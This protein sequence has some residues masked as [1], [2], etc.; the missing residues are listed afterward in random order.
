MNRN[1][2]TVSAIYASFGR[3]DVPAILARLHEDVEWEH[4]AMDH[5]IGWLR[6]RRG[7]EQV[8]GFF[9]DL[10]QVEILRFEPLNLMTG[11][12]QVASTVRIEMRV[13]ATGKAFRDLELHL[14]TFDGEGRVTR[15]R[16]LLDTHQ[17]KLAMQEE[18]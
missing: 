9:Q 14:W 16:H 13:K 18:P 4:D 6:P 5:G 1:C 17:L 15:F 7:R 8:A 10:A 12:D 2:Q 11:N 3:G